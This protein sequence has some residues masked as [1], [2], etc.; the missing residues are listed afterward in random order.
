MAVLTPCAA[1]TP[2]ARDVALLAATC[3]TCHGPGGQPPA[4][5][6]G[7]IPAL[8]GQGSAALFERMQAFKAGRVAGATVMPRLMLG[9]DTAQ[10]RALARW[11][12]DPAQEKR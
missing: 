4:G 11:F 5:A 1:Q 12:A 6:N 8:R 3:A 10:M 9:Y 7:S 2:P